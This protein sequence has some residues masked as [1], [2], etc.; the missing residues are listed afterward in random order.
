[1]LYSN[2]KVVY[3]EPIPKGKTVT[4]PTELVSEERKIAVV[5]RF[6][7]LDK[8]WKIFDV[9]IEGVSLIRSYISQF[10]DIIQKSG[11]EGL[12]EE[13]KKRPESEP[14]EQASETTSN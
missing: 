1:M 14:K 13:L 2:E 3:Q 7:Q 5:Y 6:R 8:V 11:I 4:I 12:L 9:E 10:N